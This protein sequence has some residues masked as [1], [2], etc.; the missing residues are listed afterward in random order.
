MTTAYYSSVLSQ[1]LTTVWSL[2]RDFNNY[3]AYVDGVTESIIENDKAGYEVGA[4]RRFLYNGKWTR[5]RLATHSDD[6]HLFTYVGLDP[7][8]FPA[9]VAART[10]AAARYEGTIHLLPI[11]DRDHTF[12][13]WSVTLEANPDDA[14]QWRSLLMSLIPRWTESL[15]KTLNSSSV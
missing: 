9:G 3:P 1:P 15:R 7:L 8:A 4:I 5:Q 13:E 14:E 2:I 10:P 6:Q 12:I 11:A